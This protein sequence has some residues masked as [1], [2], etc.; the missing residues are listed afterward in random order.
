AVFGIVRGGVPMNISI[1]P[2]PATAADGTETGIIG[3][4]TKMVYDFPIDVT[5]QLDNVGGPSAG[6][7]F[8][9]GIIDML[10]EGGINGGS[11][12]AG[13]GTI[14]ADGTVGA[15]GGIRQKL[16][17][18]RDAGAEYFLAPETNCNEVVGHVPDGI[19]VF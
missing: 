17:G 10:T 13:T 14:S 11:H 8:A 1:T 9:L 2:T 12:V 15:I 7:M 5:I 6:M 4:A 3:I 18:A 16:F 19:R